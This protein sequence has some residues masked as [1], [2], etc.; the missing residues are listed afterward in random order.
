MSKAT[1]RLARMSDVMEQVPV[2]MVDMSNQ[3]IEYERK[4]LRYVLSVMGVLN[5]FHWIY[6]LQRKFPRH[7]ATHL[8]K[9]SS[10]HEPPDR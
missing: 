3:R 5:C 9:I 6:P 2:D 1:P 7:V 4:I 8:F 10:E